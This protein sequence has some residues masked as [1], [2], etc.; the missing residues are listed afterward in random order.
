MRDARLRE[1]ERIRADLDVA[2][3]ACLTR[4]DNAFAELRRTSDAY[5]TA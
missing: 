5:L 4:S 2:A 3:D 1:N